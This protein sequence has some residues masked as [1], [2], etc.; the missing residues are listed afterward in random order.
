MVG[1]E[2]ALRVGFTGEEGEADVVVR[3]LGDEVLRNLLEGFDAVGLEVLCQHRGGEIDG[4]HDVDAFDVGVVPTVL[5][6]GACQDAHHEGEEQDA[7]HE[8]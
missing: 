1:R 8:G 2:R 4:Q 7:Q 5:A 3:T 6:L